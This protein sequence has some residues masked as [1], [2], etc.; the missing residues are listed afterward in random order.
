MKRRHLQATAGNS[1]KFGQQVRTLRQA[2][3]LSQRALAPM[4]GIDF[5][6]LSKIENERL[7]CAD[8]PSKGLSLSRSSTPETLLI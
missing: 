4:L 8:Y 5:T 1:M 3:G 7:D 6:Y 2:K